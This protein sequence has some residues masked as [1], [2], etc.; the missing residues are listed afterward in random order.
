MVFEIFG[1]RT[2]YTQI[3]EDAEELL[4]MWAIAT[5]ILLHYKLKLKN[6]L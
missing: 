6:N 1:L 5:D 3:I 4:F 2:P